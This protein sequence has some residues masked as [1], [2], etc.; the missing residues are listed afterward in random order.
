MTVDTLTRRGGCG[1]TAR[2]TTPRFPRLTLPDTVDWVVWFNT[3]PSTR[4]RLHRAH[5]A[6]R[7]PTAPHRTALYTTGLPLFH[8]LPTCP[9]LRC[10]IDATYNICACWFTFC[11]CAAGTQHRARF[12][13]V[14]TGCA[15]L[16]AFMR[17]L[18]DTCLGVNSTAIRHRFVT[19]RHTLPFWFALFTFAY[20]T[21]LLPIYTHLGSGLTDIPPGYSPLYLRVTRGSHTGCPTTRAG[22][23]DAFVVQ[24][25]LHSNAFS[26]TNATCRA[27]TLALRRHACRLP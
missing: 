8:R 12:N 20:S 16:T 26:F 6:Q 14:Y 19:K 22:A 2:P 9:H 17:L 4:P 3:M 15:R 25:R 13:C 5:H 23:T 7:L 21:P 18:L 24:P 1:V 11:H 27:G 10:C